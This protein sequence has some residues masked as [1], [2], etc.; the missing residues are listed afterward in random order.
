MEIY[1][2]YFIFLTRKLNNNQKNK[3]TNLTNEIKFYI[4]ISVIH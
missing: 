2:S 3:V 4:L 1:F